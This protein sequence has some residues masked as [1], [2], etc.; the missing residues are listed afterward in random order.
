MKLSGDN[1]TTRYEDELLICCARVSLEANV[2]SQVERLLRKKLDWHTVMK[3]CWWHRIRPLTYRHLSAQPAG[4]VPVAFLEELGGYVSELTERNQRLSRIL[5]EVTALFEGSS[6]PMLAFKGPTLAL[7]AY[8]HLNLRECGDLDVLICQADFPRVREVLKANGFVCLW[9]QIAGARER[10]VFACE[11]RRGNDELDV[12]W[13][14]APGWH[15]YHV[16]FDRL[17]E[18]GLPFTADSQFVRKLRPEDAVDVLCM[19]G[20]KHWWERLR[21]ICDIAELVNSG[22]ITDWSMAAEAAEARCQRPVSLGLCLA[23][24]LLDAKLPEEVRQSLDQSPVV[25]RLAAQVG[26][27]LQN[28][29]HAEESRKLPERFLFRMRLCERL[30]DR[31]QQFAHYLL[32]LPSRSVN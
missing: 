24:D 23:G 4:L 15:N 14:L 12:H 2:Q 21:W 6:L 26:A 7:D 20:T 5:G 27:W 11:F 13:D 8:G 3:R 18:G 30:R 16:D 10:Q 17:W 32:T 28:G 1:T 22:S 19:H 31:L 29:E 9:D 25:K